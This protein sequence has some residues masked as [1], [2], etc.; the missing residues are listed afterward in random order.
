MASRTRILTSHHQTGK[1][2]YSAFIEAVARDGVLWISE[3]NEYTLTAVDEDG[4]ELLP[5]WPSAEATAASLS[6]EHRARGFE[7]V[8]RDLLSWKNKS[9]PGLIRENVLVGVFPN[10]HMESVVVDVKEVNSDL[11]RAIK[12]GASPAVLQGSDLARLRRKLIRR[13]PRP[14]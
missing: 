1:E 11:D 6:T 3:S 8:Q 14:E 7:P 10:E 13:K 9:T 12:S 4:R 5:V 2:R